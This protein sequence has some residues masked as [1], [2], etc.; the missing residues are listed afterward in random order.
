MI[1]DA[2]RTLFEYQMQEDRRLWDGTIMALPEPAFKIDTG[3]SWGT[4]QREC[5]HV[6]DV[7]HAS[8]ERLHGVKAAS[9][10]VTMDDP[11]REQIRAA[12]DRVEARW[13]RYLAELDDERFH[14]QIDIVYRDT[15]MTTPVWQT[16]FHCLNHN[17]LHRAEM[18]QMVVAIGGSTDADRGFSAHCLAQSE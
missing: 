1:A 17:T 15:A 16:I 4:L 13:R 11:S 14:E 2:I 18:R 10:A 12:W 6:V 3:Y 7:M 9:V 8:L 5:A